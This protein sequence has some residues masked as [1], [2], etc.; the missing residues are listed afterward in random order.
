MIDPEQEAF[1]RQLRARTRPAVPLDDDNWTPRRRWDEKGK[2]GPA[3]SLYPSAR[4]RATQRYRERVKLREQ[5]EAEAAQLLTQRTDTDNPQVVD[6][7]VDSD[8]GAVGHVVQV[9]VHRLAVR[10]VPRLD[11]VAGGQARTAVPGVDLRP[12]GVADVDGV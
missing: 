2:P 10:L 12:D 3:P 8:T 5:A 1:R 4:T 7:S 6:N 9:V 11:L